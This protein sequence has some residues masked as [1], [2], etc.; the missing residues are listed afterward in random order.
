MSQSHAFFRVTGYLCGEFTGHRWI[1][2]VNNREAGDWRR[3]LAHYDV[4]VIIWKSAISYEP[5]KFRNFEHVYQLKCSYHL[6][7]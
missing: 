4:T 7:T 3:R 1:P 2:Q 6:T 5:L